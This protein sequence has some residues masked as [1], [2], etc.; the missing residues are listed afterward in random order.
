MYTD[1]VLESVGLTGQVETDVTD[2]SYSDG[3]SYQI[4][5]TN[6]SSVTNAEAQLQASN[7]NS[8]WIAVGSATSITDGSA[9]E[10]L[11]V[12]KDPAA[13][14]YSRLQFTGGDGGSFDATV[15][16]NTKSRK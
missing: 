9:D 11:L 15:F 13:F 5:M 7:D 8:N 10:V 6:K 3:L 1:K 16:V 2:L 14:R 12:V 4:N